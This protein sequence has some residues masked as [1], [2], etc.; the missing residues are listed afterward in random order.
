MKVLLAI[1]TTANFIQASDGKLYGM[2]YSGGSSGAGVI[3]SFDP[4]SSTYTK[5]KDFD[6]TNGGNPYGSLMQ[7]SDGKLY[8]MTA[9]GGSS[10][11]GVIFSFD[12]SSSTYTKL[13]DFDGTN[14]ANPFGSLMQAS[15][16]KLYGMT[17]DGGSSGDGVIF[18]FD[19]SSSTYTKLKDFDDTNGAYPSW[20]PYAGKRWKAIWH[21]IRVE[22]AA[23]LVLFFP[24]ILPLPLIQS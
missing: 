6:G 18:S 2:T 15:D 4:S 17:D 22:E 21:D 20:Q 24:L 1:H 11:A 3:F 16:G 13:K 14:G 19:P 5:L 9:Q 23:M 12:P 7:A 8:G 10:G